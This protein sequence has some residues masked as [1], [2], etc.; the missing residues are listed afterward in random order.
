MTLL[1]LL[2]ETETEIEETGDEEAADQRKE[3]K[4]RTLSS[5]FTWARLTQE[6]LKMTSKPNSVGS[7]PST[8]SI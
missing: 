5:L 3:E 2:Q 6:Q 1:I 8:V 4:E 7:D